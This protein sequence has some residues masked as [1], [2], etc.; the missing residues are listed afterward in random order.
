MVQRVR[1]SQ[2]VNEPGPMSEMPGTRGEQANRQIRHKGRT[3]Q[4]ANRSGS[5]AARGRNGKGRK[6]H[7]S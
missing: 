5:K 7:N 4:R 1:M 2:R 6:S 3:N